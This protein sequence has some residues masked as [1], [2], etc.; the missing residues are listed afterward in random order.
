MN[1]AEELRLCSI[2][3]HGYALSLKVTPALGGAL[4]TEQG[5]AARGK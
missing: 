2:D 5:C 3:A 1:L 4:L